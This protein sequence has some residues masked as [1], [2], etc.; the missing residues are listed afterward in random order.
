MSSLRNSHL[1]HNLLL[2]RDEQTYYVI[3]MKTMFVCK[4]FIIKIYIRIRKFTYW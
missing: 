1:Q 4:Y 2:I 3:F